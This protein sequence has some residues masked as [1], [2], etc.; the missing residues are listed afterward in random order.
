M[1]HRIG[2]CDTRANV[3]P[4]EDHLVEALSPDD[5]LDIQHERS[6]RHL[7]GVSIRRPRPSRVQPDH[8]EALECLIDVGPH[9]WNLSED[10]GDVREGVR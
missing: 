8:P 1:G 3:V 5:G 4:E 7:G 2:D 9:G 6:E 10:A